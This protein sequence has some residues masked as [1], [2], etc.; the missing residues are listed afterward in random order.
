MEFH[1]LA[2]KS[3]IGRLRK[4]I[5]QEL[6]DAGWSESAAFDCLVA[7]SEAGVNAILH[8]TEEG[9]SRPEVGWA[10]TPQTAEFLIRNHSSRG[11]SRRAQPS[12][13]R[14]ERSKV[15]RSGGWGLELME[16]LMDEVSID[17]GPSQTEVRLFKR[18]G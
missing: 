5:Q 6:V 7:V 4:R 3:S 11:W 17:A 16:L 2:D 12:N 1:P 9:D 13:K 18:R 14:R 15:D 10:V 8:G